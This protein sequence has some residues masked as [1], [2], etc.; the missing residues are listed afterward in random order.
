MQICKI[1]SSTVDHFL[2]DVESRN[3]AENAGKHFSHS[4]YTAS[5]LQGC[6]IQ[7]RPAPTADTVHLGHDV[8]RNIRFRRNDRNPDLSTPWS[9]SRCSGAHSLSHACPN[10]SASVSVHRCQSRHLRSLTENSAVVMAAH[11]FR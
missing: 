8:I 11:D 6:E 2:T 5:N 9:C 7:R 1:H 4:S 3:V 10:L